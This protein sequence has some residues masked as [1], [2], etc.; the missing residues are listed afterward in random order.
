[1]WLWVFAWL[2]LSVCSGV[3]A[4]YAVNPDPPLKST[5]GHSSPVFALRQ[6]VAGRGHNRAENFDLPNEHPVARA[7]EVPHVACN[8]EYFRRFFRC[9]GWGVL[10]IRKSTRRPLQLYAAAGCIDTKILGMFINPEW[11]S[12]YISRRRLLRRS[13]IF[14]CACLVARHP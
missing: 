13:V 2:C 10:L 7:I 14:A 8:H 1:M 11:A 4:L 12:V 9:H 5:C 3:C 6:S